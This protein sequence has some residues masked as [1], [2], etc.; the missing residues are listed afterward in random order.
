MQE[1]KRCGFDPLVGKI[2]W[3]NAWQ[4]TPVFL[5]GEAP[6]TEEP[7]GLQSIGSQTVGHNQSNLALNIPIYGW[8]RFYIRIMVH[9]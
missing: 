2:P 3:G 9:S 7:G 5:P 1:T 4:P 8:T 6:W